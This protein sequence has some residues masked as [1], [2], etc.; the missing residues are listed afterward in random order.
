MRKLRLLGLCLLV[1]A[2][3]FTFTSC[4]NSDDDD[5]GSM[6]PAERAQSLQVVRGSY[7]GKVYAMG[8]NVQSGKSLATDSAEVS[9]SIDTDSTM[10][11]Y[12]VPSRLLAQCIDTTTAEHKAIR[13]AV[14]KQA[15]SNIRCT[16]SFY[17]YYKE[18]L[19]YPF[20][21]I[22]PLRVIYN[23]TANGGNHKVTVIFWGN[24]TS[25]F[26]VYNASKKV[27]S[28]E[29]LMAGALIDGVSRSTSLSLSNAVPLVF[30]KK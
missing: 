19:S 15:P 13:D 26:G 11:F 4:L 7:S 8:R 5:N 25:S 20:W 18:W 16:I 12:N 3:A 28:L 14:V 29:V 17:K 30:V 2:S 23:V 27:M 22:N 6:T 9:W 10:A 24:S 21:F 1:A